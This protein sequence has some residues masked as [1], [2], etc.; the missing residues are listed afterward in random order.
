MA[1]ATHYQEPYTLD[2][3]TMDLPKEVQERVI[4]A[5]IEAETI[6]AG[7]VSEHI[8]SWWELLVRLEAAVATARS[9]AA[10]LGGVNLKE[11]DREQKDRGR[12]SRFL[13]SFRRF[14]GR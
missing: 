11:F 2:L 4:Q 10:F 6:R 12:I 14:L 8:M 7:L 1:E 5:R 9:N 13:I 3:E